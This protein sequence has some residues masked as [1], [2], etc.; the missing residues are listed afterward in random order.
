MGWLFFIILAGLALL[1]AYRVWRSER[2]RRRRVLLR[3]AGVFA[4]SYGGL[5]VL[6]MLLESWLL[7][8]P[9]RAEHGW[10]P[11]GELAVEDVW[12]QARTGERIHAWWCPTPKHDWVLLY[13]HGNAGNLSFRRELIRHWQRELNASVLIFDYPGFGKSAGKPTEAGCY[14]AAHAAYDWLTTVQQVPAGELVLYGKS[15]GGA[16]AVELAVSRPHAALVIQSSFTSLPDLGQE[17]FFFLPVRW[18]VRSRYDSRA[19][20]EHYTGPLFVGHGDQDDLIPCRHGERLYAACPSP[21]KQFFCLDACGHNDVG[22]RDFYAA[23]KQFLAASRLSA[24]GS[25]LEPGLP[26]R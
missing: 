19:R 5:I 17:M 4:F 20:L 6:L 24:T 25:R 14:A 8:H 13:C 12:L 7:Y 22:T 15:L 11:P 21:T 23:V 2:V 16:M 3:E 10:A 9:Y 18:L 26:G 1:S